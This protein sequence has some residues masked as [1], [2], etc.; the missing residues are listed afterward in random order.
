M[1]EQQQAQL[2]QAVIPTA[3]EPREDG[4]FPYAE[5]IVLNK[6]KTH[7]WRSFLVVF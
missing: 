5:D 7:A 6:T 1:G 3:S 2:E 4:H